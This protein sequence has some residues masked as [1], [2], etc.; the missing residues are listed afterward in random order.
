MKV[1]VD[2]GVKAGRRHVMAS[3]V[4]QDFLRRLGTKWSGVVTVFNTDFWEGRVHTLQVTVAGR[5]KPWPDMYTLR[6]PTVDVLTVITDGR[7]R[8]VALV[9]QYRAAAGGRV[10]S[11]VAG[12]IGAGE[13]VMAA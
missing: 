2:P 13:D 9:E 8:Y 1:V 3:S 4:F 6:G 7:R 10:L 5:G 11:N 12:G